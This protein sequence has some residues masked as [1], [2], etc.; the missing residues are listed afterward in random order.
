[1]LLLL[2]GDKVGEHCQGG[3]DSAPGCFVG[4][5]V[6]TSQQGHGEDARPPTGRLPTVGG[7]P[8][9]MAELMA[10]TPV[11]VWPGC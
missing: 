11:P 6:S 1:M 2:Q 9:V 7:R 3:G 10:V 5:P 4:A 8:A